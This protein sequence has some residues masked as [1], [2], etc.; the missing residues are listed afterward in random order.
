MEKKTVTTYKAVYRVPITPFMTRAHLVRMS[1]CQKRKWMKWS[2]P[3][4][5]PHQK[6][7]KAKIIQD[8]SHVQNKN[9]WRNLETIRISNILTSHHLRVIIPSSLMVQP[10]P[11]GVLWGNNASADFATSSAAID[12]EVAEVLAPGSPL[13]SN[14]LWGFQGKT[15]RIEI[16]TLV[17]SL[18][19]KL[20]SYSGWLAH[21]KLMIQKCRMDP[22]MYIDWK[23]YPRVAIGSKK[24]GT[25]ACS[26]GAPQLGKPEVVA[27]HS[28]MLAERWNTNTFCRVWMCCIWGSSKKKTPL[29][30]KATVTTTS[31]LQSIQLQHS[32][33]TL[34]KL[35]W[36]FHQNKNPPS[37]DAKG[38]MWLPLG[39]HWPSVKLPQLQ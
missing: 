15:P 2:C 37:L 12:T 11:H 29:R 22:E 38:T 25:R 20:S 14:N 35:S 31:L 18:L 16:K 6:Q 28:Q 27:L 9:F 17:L 1:C 39:Q 23:W 7:T 32:I 3:T 26:A 13:W 4:R 19:L 34:D 30:A 10:P 21:H 5:K 36:T 24:C 8:A 33:A